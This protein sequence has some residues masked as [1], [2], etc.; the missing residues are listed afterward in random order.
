MGAAAG[1]GLPQWNC[2]CPNCAAVRAGRLQPRLQAAAFSPDGSAWYLVNATPDLS[3]QL[4]RTPVLH[5]RQRRETPIAGVVLT[6][7][8]LDHVLGLLHLREGAGWNIFA[9]G[10]TATLLHEAFPA[11]SILSRYVADATVETLSFSRPHVFGEGAAQVTMRVLE[12]GT[13]LPR[14][15]GGEERAG[16]GTGAFRAD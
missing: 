13:D 10:S 9:T 7:G 12:T 16:A 2:A 14:Y 4:L 8:E 5:P 15:A 6:D 1:G 3:T 11:L